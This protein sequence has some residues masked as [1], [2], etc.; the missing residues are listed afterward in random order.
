MKILYSIKSGLIGFG[1]RALT[2]ISKFVLLIYLAKI[3]SPEQ[4]GIYGIFVATVSYALYFLGLDFYRYASREM[5]AKDK[6]QWSCMLRD[7]LVFYC[8]VYLIVL[9]FLSF[10]FLY[11]LLHWNYIFWFYLILTL[12]HLSQESYRLLVVMHRANLANLALLFRGGAWVYVVVYIMYTNPDHQNLI[13]VW[14]GWGVGAFSSILIS[15]A[16]IYHD[17]NWSNVNNINI[18]WQWIKKGFRNAMLFFIGTLALRGIFISD[19][20]VLK[21]V[22][23][24]EAVGVYVFFFGITSSILSFVDAGVVSQQYPKIMSAFNKGYYDDYQRRLKSMAIN[25][26]LVLVVLV[27][28]LLVFIYPVL[29][30]VGKSIYANE[31][32]VFWLLIVANFIT[33]IAYIPYFPLYVKRRDIKILS[34]NI[35]GLVVMLCFLIWLTPLYGVVGTAASMVAA[36]TSILL[37][38]TLYVIYERYYS[39]NIVMVKAD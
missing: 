13:S 2:L 17:L 14:T 7:Q 19:R 25:I 6:D 20:Y 21:I 28:G 11:E 1:L 36:M 35:I 33:C 16:L 29:E 31:I 30:F 18:N 26:V 3:L 22:N 27:L 10:I 9:P 39:K 5:L 38:Q 24:N 23:G 12:E 15:G 32:E 8:I 34:S 37:V 4:I